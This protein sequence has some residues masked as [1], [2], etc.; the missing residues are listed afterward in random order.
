MPQTDIPKRILGCQAATG[1]LLLDLWRTV[2]PILD[3]TVPEK[4]FSR[5]SRKH[6]GPFV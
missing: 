3:R 2:T 1:G 4:I 5:P 6:D